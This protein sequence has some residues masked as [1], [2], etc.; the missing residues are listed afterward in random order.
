MA[1][2]HQPIVIRPARPV[3]MGAAALKRT[4]TTW[5]GELVWVA[6]AAVLGF[7][8]SAVFAGWLEVSRSWFVLAYAAVAAPFILGYVRWSGIDVVGLIRR[9]LYWGLVAGA[10]IG[11]VVVISVQRQDGGARAGG[12]ELAFDLAWW[13]VVY[14]VVDA[15]LLNV[16]PIL[17]TW[18][19][20]T[21]LGW[22]GTW[23]RRIPAGALA[24]GASVLV[25]AAYHLGFPEFRDADLAKPLAGDVISLGY[26]LTN[27]PLTAVVSHVAMHVAAVLHGAEGTV[28]LPPHY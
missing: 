10:L 17:A 11:A 22:T 8:V 23:R 9:H 18:R 5:Q 21:K 6:T 13:G 19:A 7:A 2:T 14:G 28:Q 15:L 12:W 3:S 16:L 26:L 4:E 1:T 27:N 20:M 25:T 24:L